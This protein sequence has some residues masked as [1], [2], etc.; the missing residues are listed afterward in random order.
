M[1]R[2]G[3]VWVNLGPLL[4]HWADGGSGGGSADEPSLEL[5]LAEVH[6]AARLVGFEPLRATEF[7]DAAYIGAPPPPLPCVEDLSASACLCF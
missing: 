1:L 5:S 3:G 4:W 2:P 6:R 7:V